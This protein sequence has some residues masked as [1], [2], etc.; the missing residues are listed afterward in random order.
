MLDAAEGLERH[1]LD[2]SAVSIAQDKGSLLTT[3]CVC[4]LGSLYL[5]TQ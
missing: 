2:Y 5:T 1:N 4:M 3:V